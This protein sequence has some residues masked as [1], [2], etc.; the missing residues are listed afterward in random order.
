MVAPF[1]WIYVCFAAGIVSG[2][3]IHA[4]V[5]ALLSA[6]V[7]AGFSLRSAKF[8]LSLAAQGLFFFLLAHQMTA[9][10][11]EEYESNPLRKWVAAHE[12]ETVRLSGILRKTPEI[13]DDYFVLTV[14]TLTVSQKALHGI[15]RITVSGQAEKYPVAGD[16]LEAFARFR[17]PVNFRA[18]GCFDYERYLEKEGVHVLGSVKNDSLVRRTKVQRSIRSFIS[19]LRLNLILQIQRR[20]DFRDAA[21]LRALWLDDR[22]A[23]PRET[24]RRLIDAGVFH[25]IAISGFHVAVLLSL[26]FLLLRR[27]VPYRAALILL[28]SLLGFYFILLEG[29]SSITRSF[30]TFLIFAV[31]SWR[32]EALRAGNILFLSAWAQLVWNPLELFDPGYH[33]TYLSTAS[34]LFVAVPLCRTIH[35]SRRAYRYA[36]DLGIASLTIQFVLA[37]YQA[38]VFHRIPLASV[39]ANLIAVPLSSVLIAAGAICLPLGLLS[40]TT[41][42]LI[43]HVLA[44]FL[45]GTFLLSGVWL[46]TVPE[47]GFLVVLLFYLC[48]AVFAASRSRSLRV[49]ALFC[50]C[51][52]FYYVLDPNQPESVHRLRVHFID[53]GQGDAILLEY[54][55][56]TFDLVDGGGFWN[57]EALDIG[58]A[59]L[60]PYLSHLKVRRLNRVFLTHAHSDHMSGLISLLRYISAKHFYVT[61]KPLADPG[62][63]NL[64]RHVEIPLEGIHQGKRFVQGGVRLEVL[65][66]GDSGNTLHVRN[67]DSLVLLVEYEGSRLLL[68]GDAEAETETELIVSRINNLRVD[69]LKSPHH[70]S[71]SS[72][73]APFLDILKM[74]IVFISLGRNN[75]FGHPSVDVLKRYRERHAVV[76]RTDQI[77]TIRLTMSGKGAFVD[78]Y[79]WSH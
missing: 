59:V 27:A 16:T 61:R 26:A 8:S 37:P 39:A 10:Q 5:W 2:L 9:T 69:F 47:P 75:W 63:Q 49:F 43:H 57:P 21:L 51:G 71:K 30:F 55:D 23:L 66:P 56:G 35:I 15:A 44:L 72:S 6:A 64:V 22:S 79:R 73:I 38:L 33:L 31:A 52:L 20:F 62:Y 24:E 13:A 53:V 41:V 3:H 4:G 76:Y 1:V 42:W 68:P 46:R 48:L 54:P 18:E 65:A 32:C 19:V 34:I 74:K 25:V 14:E 36:V 40:S 60:L 28:C 12:K 7:V 67:D 50:C 58:E 45:Q 78:S 29:R 11:A 77:G 17:L 70:G